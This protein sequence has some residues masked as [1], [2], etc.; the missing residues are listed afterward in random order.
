M[1]SDKLINAY[2]TADGRIFVKQSENGRKH[3]INDFQDIYDPGSK[4]KPQT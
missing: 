4:Y 1:K 3:I 2:W